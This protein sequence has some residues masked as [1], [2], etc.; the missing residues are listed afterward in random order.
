MK[1]LIN[2]TSMTDS[3]H[4]N[5]STAIVDFINDSIIS[6]S[7]APAFISLELKATRRSRIVAERGNL[8]LDGL[9]ER[10]IQP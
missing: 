2:A 4:R 8:C 5:S 10:G 6:Y 3:Q 1:L 9:V 7:E